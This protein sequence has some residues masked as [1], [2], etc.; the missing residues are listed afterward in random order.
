MTSS[1]LGITLYLLVGGNG[2]TASMQ[3]NPDGTMYLFNVSSGA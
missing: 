2:G 1:H 3:I